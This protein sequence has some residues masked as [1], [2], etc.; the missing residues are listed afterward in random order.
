MQ[1]HIFLPQIIKDSLAGNS[2]FAAAAAFNV[3][4]L[5]PDN[6]PVLIDDEY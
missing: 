4:D 3:G 5:A 1:R 6:L 2:I